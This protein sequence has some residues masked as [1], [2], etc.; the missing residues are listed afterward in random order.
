MGTISVLSLNRLKDIQ[1]EDLPPYED[2][3]IQSLSLAEFNKYSNPQS[4]SSLIS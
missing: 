4:L 2:S 3:M 1:I